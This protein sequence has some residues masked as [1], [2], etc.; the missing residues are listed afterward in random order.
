METLLYALRHDEAP[1]VRK[2]ALVNV[3]ITK[4]TIPFLIE[5][6]RDVDPAIRKLVYSNIMSEIGDMRFFSIADRELILS[7]GLSD[8]N[9]AVK[10]MC[11][12]MVTN[13]WMKMCNDNLTE[14]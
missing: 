2:T 4:S 8:R 9:S 11:L 1:S 10:S 14:V 5:R 12:A 3:E 13:C 7:W 6:I